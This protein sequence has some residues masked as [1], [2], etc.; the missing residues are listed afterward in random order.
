MYVCTSSYPP[1]L[2][3]LELQHQLPATRFAVRAYAP[4]AF[5]S[6][7]VPTPSPTRSL[8]HNL[9]P[10]II[11]GWMVGSGRGVGW[12]LA[13]E[14]KVWSI[15]AG[16]ITPSAPVRLQRENLATIIDGYGTDHCWLAMMLLVSERP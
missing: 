8:S 4:T 10:K 1:L 7:E 12:G 9:A 3:I 13:N 16:P 14:M 15:G 5:G 6:D 11:G 2:A